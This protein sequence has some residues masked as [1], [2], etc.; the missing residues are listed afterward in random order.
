MSQLAALKERSAELADHLAAASR[1]LTSRGPVPDVALADEL[2]VVRSQFADL[3]R[4]ALELAAAVETCGLES[5]PDVTSLA[6][7]EKLVQTIV[8][9]LER[10]AR[11]QAKQDAQLLLER[12]QQ[13]RHHDQTDLAALERCRTLATELHQALLQLDSPAEHI[14][15]DDEDDWP[16]VQLAA[17]EIE[18][19]P[20]GDSLDSLIWQAVAADRPA[21][22]F[23]LA[24]CTDESA[25]GSQALPAWLLRALALSRHVQYPNGDIALQLAE[26]FAAYESAEADQTFS[27]LLAAAALRP[28]LV[29][30]DTGAWATVCALPRAEGLPNFQ[31]L[32]QHVAEY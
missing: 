8:V 6:D 9:E 23:L 32:L 13:L 18:A 30:P 21:V 24:T 22:A 4:I 11:R 29:A 15:T 27:L 12:V 31:Q 26:D 14:E 16:T 10:R 2:D 28:T 7:L 3:H 20:P 5:S 25:S 1:E 19:P 17:P